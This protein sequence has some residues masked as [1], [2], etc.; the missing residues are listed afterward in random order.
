M[1]IGSSSLSAD[2]EDDELDMF[3]AAR[4]RS[5][6]RFL[7]LFC[8]SLLTLA[9]LTSLH[10]ALLLGIMM[11]QVPYYFVS[12]TFKLYPER[13]RFVDWQV[14]TLSDFLLLNC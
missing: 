3:L 10:T 6:L 9:S 4:C 11:M 12:V 13:E 1:F 14:T 2:D 8:L 7:Y 5:F